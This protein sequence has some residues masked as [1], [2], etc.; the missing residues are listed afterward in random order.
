VEGVKKALSIIVL[1]LFAQSLQAQEKKPWNLDRLCGRLEHVQ[2]TPS[3]RHSNNFSER[4][5]ALRNVSLSLYERRENEPCCDGVNAAETIQTGRGGHFEFKTKKAGTFLLST[6]W[7][8]KEYRLSVVYK[9]QKNSATT[10]SDQGI[11]LDGEG[12]ADWWVT[13]TVD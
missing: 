7:S 3:R 10:C 9:P 8:G 4:R 6:N 13:V 11:A 12:N 2:R 1:M 5:K